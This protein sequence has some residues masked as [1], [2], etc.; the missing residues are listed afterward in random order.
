MANSLSSKKSLRVSKRRNKVNT[1]ST[2]EFKKV[3]K[4][5]KD[6]LTKNDVKGAKETLSKAYSKLDMAVK[7]KVI[8]KNTAARY[9]SGIA[10]LVK[11]AEEKKSETKVEK[12]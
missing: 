8:H 3:R 2:A 6:K 10:G 11:K 5:V 7:K 1:K 12:K 4:S 9:K